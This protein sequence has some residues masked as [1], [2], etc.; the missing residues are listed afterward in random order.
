MVTAVTRRR[1]TV[2]EYHWM[3]RVGILDSNERVELLDGEVVTMAAKGD[4]HISGLAR[5][6]DLL[7]DATRGRATVIVQDPIHLSSYSE[8]EPDLTLLHRR[9]DYYASGKPTPADVFLVIEVSDTTFDKDFKVKMPLYA[10]AGILEAW[11]VDIPRRRLL[12]FRTPESS[13]YR[14]MIE[15]GEGASVTLL[16]FPDVTVSHA[17]LFEGL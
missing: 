8:P 6:I 11:L 9:A 4:K 13:G 2:E 3:A 10:A 16:A 1:F 7:G 12:V 5:L 14:E 17:F 15:I